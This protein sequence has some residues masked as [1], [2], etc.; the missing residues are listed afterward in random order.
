VKDPQG[1]TVAKYCLSNE[2]ENIL[3]DD[4]KVEENELKIQYFDVAMVH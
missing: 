1:V 3:T 2:L 4:P